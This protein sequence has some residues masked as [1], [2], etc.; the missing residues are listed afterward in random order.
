MLLNTLL[1]DTQ[2]F[3]IIPYATAAIALPTICVV[4]DRYMMR[5]IPMLFCY[6]LCA[7]GFTLLM[8]TTSQAARIVGTCLVS[9]GSY[10][11]VILAA[12]WVMSSHGGY[13][14]RS[15]AWALCQL[16]L[17]CYSIMGTKIYDNPPRF[18]KG[19]G[20]ILGFVTLAA[21]C[22]VAKWWLMR[23]ANQRREAM[24]KQYAQRG[25]A[26]PGIEKS[27]EEL[28]DKHPDF[29]YLL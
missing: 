22:I 26:V 21:A 19:H 28:N 23:S 6:L 10:S 27:I 11:G 5:A 1:V 7:C 20:I 2:L 13:T 4:A 16:F 29:R 17:Q 3:T 24:K 12:T 8:A 14:K 9:S 15:T 18:L 25:E